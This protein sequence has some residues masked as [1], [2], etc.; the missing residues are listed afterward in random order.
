MPALRVSELRH[1]VPRLRR[2]GILGSAHL[3]DARRYPPDH[4][5]VGNIPDHYRIGADNDVI[6]DAYPPKN[7][8]AGAELDTAADSGR[9]KRV[10]EAGVAKGHTM[11]D[12]AVVADYGRA[13]YDNASM[14][15]DGQPPADGRGAAD[16][17]PAENLDELVEYDVGDRPGRTHHLV[18][19]REAGVTEAVDEKCPETD[20]QQPFALRFEVFQQVHHRDQE[21]D[22][23][24]QSAA[25]ESY[26]IVAGTATSRRP[27]YNKVKRPASGQLSGVQG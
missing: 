24:I 25:A 2:R 23:D 3:Q 5:K 6:T 1:A 26:A 16:A 19:D 12:Q 22:C 7:F 11:T 27:Y 17:D 9:A 20:A 18:A 10:V 8:R 15:L 14:V 21:A 4:G 13:M